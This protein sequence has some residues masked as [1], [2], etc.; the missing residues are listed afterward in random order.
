ME[1][2]QKIAGLFDGSGEINDCKSAY[3]HPF[4]HVLCSFIAYI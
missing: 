2:L 1:R 4:W 3:I